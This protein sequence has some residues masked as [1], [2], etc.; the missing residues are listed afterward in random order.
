MVMILLII[1]LLIGISL[2]LIGAGGAIVAVPALVYIGHIDPVLAG[3]YALFIVTFA[4]LVSIIL[5]YKAKVISW[6]AVVPLASTTM[7]T[8]YVTRTF[9]LANIPAEFF[10][11]GYSFQRNSVLMISFAIVLTLAGLSMAR[12]K[13][14]APEHH[15]HKHPILLAGYGVIIGFVSGM[16][17]V[18]GGFLI[19][20]ALVV[21]AGLDMKHAVGTSLV[22]MCINSAVGVAADTSHGAQYDWGFLIPFTILTTIG[23]IV[24]TR[25]A[26]KIHSK[27]LKTGYAVFVIMLGVTVLALEV[28]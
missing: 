17:G 28:F 27:H 22:V 14:E 23:I 4:T 9:I 19:T 6:R 26:R 1:A 7:L 15:H 3:G 21:W 16:L 10:V 24:G 5:N 18:G 2:G 8:V 11:S 20:P 12:H 13:K 25:M